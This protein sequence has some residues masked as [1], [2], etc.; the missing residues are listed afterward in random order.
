MCTFINVECLA[1]NALIGLY[2]NGE[3]KISF[4]KLAEYGLLVV[5]QYKR[6]N[7]EDAVFIFDPDAIL[8]LAI[9]YSGFFDIISEDGKQRYL[10]LKAGVEIKELKENFR[11]TLSYAMLKVISRINVMD[12]MEKANA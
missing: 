5:E 6:E 12:I 10:S 11:W 8:G 9:N 3:T 1:A 4:N 2:E 7:A